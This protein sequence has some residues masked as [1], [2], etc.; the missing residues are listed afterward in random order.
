MRLQ[1]RLA[2][3]L[4]PFRL[5]ITTLTLVALLVAFALAN[6]TQAQES[7]STRQRAEIFQA[8]ADAAAHALVLAIQ[9]GISSLPPTSGQ[10]FVYEFDPSVGAFVRSD[11]VGPIVLRAAETIRPGRLTL[12]VAT[13]YFA[14]GE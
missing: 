14:L 12:R 11:R 3:S 1:G 6:L 5:G 13:S 4:L 2:T 9:Q 10:S 7:R 8:Q